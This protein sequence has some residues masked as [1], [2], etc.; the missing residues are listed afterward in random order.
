MVTKIRDA[1]D[2]MKMWVKGTLPNDRTPEPTP[3]KAELALM[4]EKFEKVVGRGYIS[5][6]LVL[7]L[8]TYFGVPK[9]LDDIRLVYDGACSGLNAALCAPL[10][11]MPNAASAVRVVSFYTF[12]FDSDFGEYFLNFFNDPDIRSYC[13]V[14]LTPFHDKIKARKDLVV[15]SD[16]ECW[17]CCFMGLRPSPYN[18]IRYG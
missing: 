17:N 6:G 11:W 16:L 5:P 13:G 1:R 14:D 18:A 12:V 10:L 8:T 15:G 3:K 2:G 9:G 4:L 7:S